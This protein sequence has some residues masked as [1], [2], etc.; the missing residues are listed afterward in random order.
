VSLLVSDDIRARV[1]RLGIP[2]NAHGYDRFGTSRNHLALFF[3]LTSTLYR[4]YF[5]VRCHGIEHVPAGGRAMLIGNHSGGYA[6]DGLMTITSLFLEPE[7]PRLAQGMAEKFL[8]A[9]PVSALW[10]Q[11]LGHL[12]GIPEHAEQ[13]L[14][15]DRVL[16][17]FPEGA[18][19][20]AKLYP[21]RHSLVRF[22][23]GF[24][25]LAMKMK[26]PIVPMAFLGGGDVLPTVMNLERL[27]RMVGVPYIPVTPYG[28]ALPLPRACDIHYGAPIT[29]TGSGDEPDDVI[30]QHVAVVRDR[31][32]SMMA[33]G[34]IEHERR[35]RPIP[36]LDRIARVA[37]GRGSAK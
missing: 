15:D 35:V 2:W 24:M 21:E 6:I 7:P 19:G 36:L 23:T 31:I 20:T 10:T 16:M 30:E 33:A 27:G 34:R 11:R 5:D 9:L 18:R 13:L 28:L 4:R 12:A 1:E 26:T 14:A 29:I 25:R 8:S 17:I 37:G 3:G 32:A 22:G